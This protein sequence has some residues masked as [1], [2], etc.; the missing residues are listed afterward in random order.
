MKG[1]HGMNDSIDWKKKLTSRKFWAAV[2]NFV[3]ML[4]MAF[5]AS[6]GTAEKITALI[7]AG[8]TVI[9]YIIAEGL[10]DAANAGVVEIPVEE[11][12]PDEE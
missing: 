12:P 3:G 1:E 8:A 2:C 4:V 9:A 6:A 10:V 11:I 5:G 7:M